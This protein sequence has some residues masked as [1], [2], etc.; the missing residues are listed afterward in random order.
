MVIN[1]NMYM[2]YTLAFQYPRMMNEINMW[3]Y[4]LNRCLFWHHHSHFSYS[5]FIHLFFLLFTLNISTN[6]QLKY[7]LAT[8]QGVQAV[9]VAKVV[10]KVK[11]SQDYSGFDPGFSNVNQHS[12]HESQEPQMNNTHVRSDFNGSTKS[13]NQVL[14]PP[15]TKSDHGKAWS[16]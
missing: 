9:V 15:Q 16:K 7:S 3:T 1:K 11:T 10:S 4:M 14:I 6:K 5:F 2:E 8:L 12:W 13:C